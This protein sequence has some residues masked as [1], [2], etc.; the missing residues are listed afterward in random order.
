MAKRFC[1]NEFAKVQT[2]TR[3]SS[4][5]PIVIADIATAANNA[6]S[7]PGA[8]SGGAPTAATKKAPKGNSI[9]AIA[10]MRTDAACVKGYRP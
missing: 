8:S 7:K 5:A 9:I 1:G 2:A 4:S 6:A 10:S 3:F